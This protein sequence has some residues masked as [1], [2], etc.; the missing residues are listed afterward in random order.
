MMDAQRKEE[1]DEEKKAELEL[2]CTVD[3]TCCDGY[4]GYD[5]TQRIRFW[6]WPQWDKESY[7]FNSKTGIGDQSY[8]KTRVYYDQYDNSLFSY[9]DDTYS[10]Q[11]K[12]SA[13]QSWYNDDTYGGSMEL[14]TTLLSRNNLKAAFHYKRDRHKEHDNDEP[15]RTFRDEYYSIAVEDTTG[16]T[17]KLSTRVGASYD[18]Q[19][20]L[21]AEDYDSD[22]DIIS[23]F[24]TKDASAF[25][26]QA[27]LFYDFS[28]TSSAYLTVARKSRFAT[29]KD[30]Y[31]YSFGTTLPNA[32]LDP[33]IAINYDLG[34]ET[35]SDRVSF[36]GTLF[37]SDIEDYIQYATIPNLL[38]ENYEIDEGYPEEGINYFAN[39][40]YKF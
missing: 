22:T 8:V 3:D 16:L 38:D 9:D 12:R 17:E 6:Q 2:D 26:P 23:D 11:N 18:W 28:D 14:G 34:F 10:T 31:S 37:F 4:T 15:K 35:K 20:A 5:D 25:N 39:L 21:E 13:F 1:E 7:Y 24:P 36:S 27:G 29:L 19:K 32:D 33:E 30:R 40:T